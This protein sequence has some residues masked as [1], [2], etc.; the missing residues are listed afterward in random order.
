MEKMT[1]HITEGRGLWV[2]WR[3]KGRLG[4]RR[5]REGESERGRKGERGR[6][7]EREKGQ[8]KWEAERWGRGG[9]WFD[10]GIMRRMTPY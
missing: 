6:E 9:S 5:R 8:G 10:Y 4:G 1:K 2:G 3:K 7:G